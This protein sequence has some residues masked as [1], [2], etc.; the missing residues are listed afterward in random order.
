MNDQL[1]VL[2]N[3][4]KNTSHVLHL[5]LSICTGGL[6]V[7]VWVL[8]AMQNNRHNNA[9]DRKM[10]RILQSDVT[11]KP[12]VSPRESSHD[13]DRYKRQVLLVVAAVIIMVVYLI[14]R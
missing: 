8:V 3:Q 5:I 14:V 12:E 6:W 4:K 13:D 10:N 9:I 1:F 11:G 2:A 7:I